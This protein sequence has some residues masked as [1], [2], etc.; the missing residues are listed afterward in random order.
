M[1]ASSILPVVFAIGCI[2]PYDTDPQYIVCFE[3]RSD[4]SKH[5]TLQEAVD[6]AEPGDTIY[7][8]DAVIT[9]GAT[10]DKPLTLDGAGIDETNFKVI[11]EQAAVSIRDT[12][13]TIRGMT[14]GSTGGPAILADK[15]T[16]TLDK[17]RISNAGT[18]GIDAH[19]TDIVATDLHVRAS[20]ASP[21]SLG[22][23]SVDDGSLS[24][25]GESE[26][27]NVNSFGI[28]LD[29]GADGVIDG[30]TFSNIFYTNEAG[31][32]FEADGI[33]I[34]SNHLAT[35]TMSNNTFDNIAVA[36]VQTESTSL[37]M[38][39]DRIGSAFVGLLTLDTDATISDVTIDGAVG[40]AAYLRTTVAD[41]TNLV[42]AAPDDAATTASGLYAAGSVITLR[43]GTISNF[44]GGGVYV[45]AISPTDPVSLTMTDTIVEGSG[46]IGVAVVAGDLSA[47]NVTVTGTGD[48]NGTCVDPTEG[49]VCNF[50][51]YLR[52]GSATWAGGSVSHNTGYGFVLDT[53]R[54]DASDLTVDGNIRPAFYAYAAAIKLERGAL[55]D[56]GQ[57]GFD[58]LDSD[59]AILDTSFSG[60]RWDLSIPQEDGTSV[61]YYD[62]ARDIVARGGSVSIDGGTHTDGQ[63]AIDTADTAVSVSNTTFD[64]YTG[65]LFVGTGGSLTLVRVDGSALATPAISC[66]DGLVD[67]ER[68]DLQ[69]VSV[70]EDKVDLYDSTGA[71]IVGDSTVFRTPAIDTDH[72]TLYLDKTTITS[73]SV[74]PIAAVDGVME[75]SSVEV[76]GGASAAPDTTAAV[77]VGFT[78]TVPRVIAE[79]VLVTGTSAGSGIRITGEEGLDAGFVQLADIRVGTDDGA[80][81]AGV[82]GDGLQI[83]GLDA[84]LSGVDIHDAGGDC[85]D[86]EEGTLVAVGADT[87]RTGVLDGCGAV[88]VR[89]VDADADLTDLTVRDA[90]LDGLS[91]V[92]GTHALRRVIVESAT[93]Y[94]MRCDSSDVPLFSDCDVSLTG[95]L[96]ESDGCISCPGE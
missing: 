5:S 40:Y 9:E 93:A 89:L 94:G 33:G 28:S 31:Y 48:P 35:L 61:L 26:F 65:G 86:V 71:L 15:S 34:Q 21:I 63:W 58:L 49:D 80:G 90:G 64:Q 16:L 85:L 96:G 66:S 7:F 2:K 3:L 56:I 10:I 13:V 83:I 29:N 50:A 43:G 91:L 57:S 67:A 87:G 54:L 18:Y 1:R 84:T 72:C 70:R 38:S 88:G 42:L 12:E 25:S 20:S 46:E 69:G 17:V 59:A 39:G 51:V 30:A 4:E 8:C 32:L 68:L 73:A 81:H 22:G 47:T 44:G 36:A 82:P 23:V 79:S 74:A 19:E 95:S 11:G 75:W 41:M 55:T 27:S 62:A 78:D 53:S 14:L 37:S 52:E 45:P 6:A 77:S 60:A 24:I 92:G 76:L